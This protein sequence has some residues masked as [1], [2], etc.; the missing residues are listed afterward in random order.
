MHKNMIYV[1]C[2][3]IHVFHSKTIEVVSANSYL[4]SKLYFHSNSVILTKGLQNCLL[5]WKGI[6]YR[7]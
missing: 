3:Y 5:N 4:V 6:D 1:H 2:V 7:T